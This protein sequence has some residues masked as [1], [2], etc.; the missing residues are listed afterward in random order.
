MELKTVLKNSKERLT[1]L[2]RQVDAKVLVGENFV[3]GFKEYGLFLNGSRQ[4]G[5]VIGAACYTHNDALA[6]CAGGNIVNGKGEIAT[7]VPLREA[8]LFEINELKKLIESLE[9]QS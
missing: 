1:Q 2:Q 6:I 8:R 7:P 9:G 4:L 5:S 3:V